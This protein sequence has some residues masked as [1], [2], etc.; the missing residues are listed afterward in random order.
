MQLT[1]CAETMF[2][3]RPLEG[4]F[5]AIAATGV[6]GMELWGL[7]AQDVERVAAAL[8]SA[9][10]TLELFCGNRAHGL[11]DP[12]E[13]EAFLAELRQSMACAQRLGCPRLT[14]LSDAVDA[15]GIPLA[16]S[17]PLASEARMR[18]LIEGLH[19]AAEEAEKQSITLLLE[20]LNTKVD[21]PG[22]T[23]AQ[24]AQAFHLVRSVGSPR[25]RVLYDVYHMQITEGNL[26]QTITENLECIGHIHV[27]DVPGRHEPGTG[28][29]NYR[30]IAA[31]LRQCGYGGAVGLECVP[32]G[33]AWAAIG[34]FLDAFA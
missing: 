23:L 2:A 1:V 20:P 13:R 14:L 6:T 16:P 22:Y 25:L 19:A 26:I 10:C 8:Q 5:A 7:S 31:V 21:H 24:S 15:R 9:G 32:R 28:E 18:S 27:A 3:D 4:R 33:D 11:V 12:G 30:S 34:A 29:I 17:R